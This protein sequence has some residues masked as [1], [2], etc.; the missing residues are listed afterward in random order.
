MFFQLYE[1]VIL[2]GILIANES[3]NAMN[4]FIKHFNIGVLNY[5]MDLLNSFYG[6]T[7]N[8]VVMAF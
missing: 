7:F 5:E 6:Q 3:K 4:N 1:T 2:N 8:C